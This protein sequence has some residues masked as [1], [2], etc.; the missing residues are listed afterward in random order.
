MD[1]E[2]ELQPKNTLD[3]TDEQHSEVVKSWNEIRR[4]GSMSFGKQVMWN[5]FSFQPEAMKLYKFK[6]EEEVYKSQAF[7]KHSVKL[8]TALDNAISLLS[9]NEHMTNF[10]NSLGMRHCGYG[11]KKEHYNV[12]GKSIM[13]T[14][15]S[16]LADNF[17][18]STR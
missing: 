4:K 8:V 9:E 11:V 12:I 1:D 17:P 18:P 14:L 7:K 2:E 10:L 6:D 3:F 15:D 13:A 16:R 5:L